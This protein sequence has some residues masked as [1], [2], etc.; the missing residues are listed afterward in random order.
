MTTTT[1]PA[2]KLQAI[3]AALAVVAGRAEG[4]TVALDYD[5]IGQ[6][7]TSG[8]VVV[9]DV[10]LRRTGVFEFEPEGELGRLDWA[11]AWLVRV[12]VSLQDPAVAYPS[13]RKIIGSLADEVDEDYNLGSD[14][15]EV[16]NSKMVEATTRTSEPD[17]LPT[18][19]LIG[20]CR[21]EAL[22][23]MPR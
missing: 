12:Y 2:L 11:M 1:D 8:T 7:I 10:T 13:I 21:V 22:A 9:S 5:P 3:A 16:E 17:E 19:M 4:A 15:G 6:E 18:R 23:R 20:E 14:G